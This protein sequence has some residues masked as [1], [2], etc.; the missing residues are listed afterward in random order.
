MLAVDTNLVVRIVTND[1]PDQALKTV[2]LFEQGRVFIAKTVLLE[3][4]WVLKFSLP[5]FT[6]GYHLHSAQSDRT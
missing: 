6:R 2:E 3:V 4:E 1:D 5:P